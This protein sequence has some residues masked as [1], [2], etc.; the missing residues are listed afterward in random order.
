M[1]PTLMITVLIGP[2][3]CPS[4]QKN[5]DVLVWIKG[6]LRGFCDVYPINER[7][8]LGQRHGGNQTQFNNK[9][10]YTC[11]LLIFDTTKKTKHTD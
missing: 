8:T 6:H 2:I 1:T 11:M 7:Q 4:L 5:T 9:Y 10:V 3:I